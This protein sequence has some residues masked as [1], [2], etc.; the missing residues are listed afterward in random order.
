L[1]TRL[2]PYEFHIRP[3]EFRIREEEE[4]EEEEKIEIFTIRG[5]VSPKKQEALLA[6]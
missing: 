4:E 5:L 2:F 6:Y 1:E 3:Y